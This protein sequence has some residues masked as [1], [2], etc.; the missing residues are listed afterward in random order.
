MTLRGSNNCFSI[1]Q[2]PS[3]LPLMHFLTRFLL[4]FGVLLSTCV[5]AITLLAQQS[6]EEDGMDDNSF[7]MDQGTVQ[8]RGTVEHIFYIIAYPTSPKDAYLNWIEEWGFAERHD[9]G[10]TIPVTIFEQSGDGLGDIFL[11]YR[12]HLIKEKTL[13][14]APRFSLILPTGSVRK[15]LGYD[16]VGFQNNWAISLYW[17]RHFATHWNIGT[18]LL[19][20]AKE[21]FPDGG[22]ARKFLANFNFGISNAWMVNHHLN[23]VL[24]FVSNLGSEINNNRNINLFG[25]YILNPGISTNV[26]F[27]SISIIPGVSIPLTWKRDNFQPGIYFYLSL[28]HPFRKNHD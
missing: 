18:T 6:I 3:K 5:P 21:L 19:P 15:N 7:L 9:A 25:Q 11:D 27:K 4:L 12:Y 20:Y 16:S 28:Q 2:A 23:L 14:I 8:T 10:F 17:N 24:E 13:N 22:S 1:W 26:D